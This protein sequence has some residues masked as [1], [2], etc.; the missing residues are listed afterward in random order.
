MYEYS[1][2]DIRLNF[3]DIAKVLIK[4]YT[5]LHNK[6][7]RTFCVQSTRSGRKVIM[8]LDIDWKD[9]KKYIY[10]NTIKIQQNALTYTFDSLPKYK[11]LNLRGRGGG[12]II[13]QF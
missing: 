3:K 4:R 11:I 10:P 13:K 7:T 1:S 9:R 8:V 6:Y 5:L 2:S 12:N